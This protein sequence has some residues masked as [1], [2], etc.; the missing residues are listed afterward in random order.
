MG[1]LTWANDSLHNNVSAAFS[2]AVH[3]VVLTPFFVIFFS[4]GG[5]LLFAKSLFALLSIAQ[6]GKLCFLA[7]Y[8][9]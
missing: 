9:A 7:I 3:L 2:G 8:E 5:G 6:I 1:Q 4:G